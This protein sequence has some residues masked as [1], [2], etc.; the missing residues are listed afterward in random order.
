MPR[1]TLQMLRRG[2]GPLKGKRILLMGATYREDVADTRHSPSVDF[3]SWVEAEGARVDIHDYLVDEL[4]QIGRSV[5]R[6]LPA[7]HGYDSVV[8][9]VAHRQYRKLKPKWLGD[10]RPFI[11]DANS[12]LTPEQV[13]RFQSAGCKVGVIGRGDL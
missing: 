1:A 9:A 3:V 5:M 12:V 13:A 4:E 10:S 2:L 6:K 8:F 11:L 7:L